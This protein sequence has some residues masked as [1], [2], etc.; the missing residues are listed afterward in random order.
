MTNNSLYNNVIFNYFLLSIWEDEFVSLRIMNRIVL[1][2]PN[3]HKQEGHIIDLTNSNLV[4]NMDTNIT[5]SKVE[6]IKYIANMF[7]II[8]TT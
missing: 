6:K 1:C 8:L 3:S 5:N 4:N 7:L 2:N